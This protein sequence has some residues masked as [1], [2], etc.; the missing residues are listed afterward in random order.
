M[1][2]YYER[3]CN[4][5]KR[6]KCLNNYCIDCVHPVEVNLKEKGFTIGTCRLCKQHN[7]IKKRLCGNC[8]ITEDLETLA[9]TF[10]KRNQESY[11]KGYEDGTKNALEVTAKIIGA[12][13]N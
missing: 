13:R 4:C 5:G 11:D 1:A 12:D 6:R 2:R 8:S 3:C 10:E 9:K 7:L